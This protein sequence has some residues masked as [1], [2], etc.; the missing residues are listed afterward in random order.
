MVPFRTEEEI[1]T[2]DLKEKDFVTKVSDHD[3]MK[4]ERETDLKEVVAYS[5]RKLI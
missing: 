1:Q 2:S 5:L 4:L 3:T